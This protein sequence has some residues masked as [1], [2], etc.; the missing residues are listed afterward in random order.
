MKRCWIAW[1]SMLLVLALLL[2]CAAVA[3]E[4]ELANE[5]VDLTLADQEGEALDLEITIDEAE[6]DIP[7]ASDGLSL[8]ELSVDE[9]L[10]LG[11]D[12]GEASLDTGEA[13]AVNEISG[14]LALSESRDS[15]FGEPVTMHCP[16]Q[17]F[18]ALEMDPVDFDNATR[19]NTSVVLYTSELVDGEYVD[20]W[21]IENESI[22]TFIHSGRYSCLITG[23]KPGTTTVKATTNMGRYGSL[24]INVEVYEALTIDDAHF[25]D[26][27]FRYYLLHKRYSDTVK[28]LNANVIPKE[29]ADGATEL[30]LG[31]WSPPE[32]IGT[33]KSLKGLEYFPSLE[34]IDLDYD[35]DLTQ[36]DLSHNPELLK[37]F[38]QG[39]ENL[40]R[41]DV[42]NCPKLEILFCS[43]NGLQTLDVSHCPNLYSLDCSENALTSLNVSGCT[44]L[45]ALYCDGNKLTQLNLGNNPY[46]AYLECHHNPLASLSI[47][48]NPTL[49]ECFSKGDVYYHAFF[50]YEDA[51]SFVIKRNGVDITASGE[52][53]PFEYN[54]LIVDQAC[55]IVF[56]G[57]SHVIPPEPTPTPTAKPT[58][59]PTTA[60]TT[61]PT[62]KPTAT[63]T[64]TPATVKLN[65]TKAS[66]KVGKKLT[67]KATLKPVGVETTLTWSSSNKKVAKVTQKGV[68]KA[69]KPGKATITVKTGNGRKASCK[70]TVVANGTKIDKKH[71]PDA[72]FRK[73]VMTN[74]DK[75]KDG[76][77]SKAEIKAVKLINVIGYGIANLKGV[78]L[79]NNLRTLYCSNNK[80]KALDVRKNTKLERLNCE[81]NKLKALDVRRNT[82]LKF[83]YCNNN[84][85]NALNVKKLAD[86]EVL[87]CGNNRLT[88][89]DLDGNFSLRVLLIQKN[90]IKSIDI[91]DCDKLRKLLKKIK[92]PMEEPWGE[93]NTI[94][95][96]IGD[97]YS[98]KNYKCLKIDDFTKVMD[99]KRVVYKP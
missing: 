68:V 61:A 10:T 83:L 17:I 39:N 48:Y 98:E 72:K 25:P 14:G 99:G 85:L 13:A 31:W 82:K 51:V 22:I 86:L 32:D 18:A 65:K 21:E 41:I 49:V 81:N 62:A 80:L 84:I 52:E 29:Y 27:S 60:P 71:F 64:P 50:T 42:S 94:L 33:I 1:V 95:W 58:A 2:P 46:M 73:Y 67:L 87:E 20:K 89:L 44:L 47:A 77:L 24:T 34:Y 63:P 40:T 6:V 7:V 15:G 28:A 69:V 66:L 91:S 4:L 3:D 38:C 37:V 35:T 79:F 57:A 59:A 11:G 54:Y 96:E 55:A 78:E 23:H 19:A 30:D 5:S 56:D 70:I 45:R 97:E 92:E 75:N 26:P 8:D 9:S 53:W 16:D 88:K 90:K 43:R 74:F 12:A 36:L 76:A 93:E